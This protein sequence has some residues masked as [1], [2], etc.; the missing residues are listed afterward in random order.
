MTSAILKKVKSLIHKMPFNRH[1]VWISLII[2]LSLMLAA[3][4]ATAGETMNFP[5]ISIFDHLSIN[6]DSPL[7][8]WVNESTTTAQDPRTNLEAAVADTLHSF[9]C[10]EST[11]IWSCYNYAQQPALTPTDR[12]V[13]ISAPGGDIEYLLAGIGRQDRMH[14]PAGGVVTAEGRL[15]KVSRP[16]YIEWYSNNDDAIMLGIDIAKR[17]GGAGNLLVHFNLSGSLSPSLDDQV[18]TLS[19]D[20]GPVLRYSNLNAWDSTGR[21]LDAVMKLSDNVL[22]WEVDDRYA[23]YPVTIDPEWTLEQAK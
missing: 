16:G 23:V 1:F 14:S 10:D 3:S 12:G 5:D 21:T 9:T 4:P 6:P 8:P 11:G 20:T 18:L 22:V 15:L 2:L 13:L 17:P 7:N 19:D